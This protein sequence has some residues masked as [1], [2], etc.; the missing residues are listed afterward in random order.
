M[1]SQPKT[2]NSQI[3]T[4]YKASVPI[5]DHLVEPPVEPPGEPVVEFLVEL[6][7]IPAEQM[8]EV[9]TLEDECVE[10]GVGLVEDLAGSL[11]EDLVGSLAEGLVGN[12]AEGLVGSL[13]GGLAGGLAG[14]L[15]EGLAGSLADGLVGSLVE[16]RCWCV[17]FPEVH[18]VL[19]VD[20]DPLNHI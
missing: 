18:K 6:D 15:V 17:D 13:S 5:E 12:L 9:Q 10:V 8:G 16:C 1:K 3:W 7:K 14:S 19:L 20:I 4:H 2:D 11:V